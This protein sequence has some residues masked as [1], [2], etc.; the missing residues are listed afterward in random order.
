MIDGNLFAT[1]ANA[2][3]EF[4]D[5]GYI[6]CAILNNYSIILHLIF[7]IFLL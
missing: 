2:Y 5:V 6:I 7:C 1:N 4:H 3:V